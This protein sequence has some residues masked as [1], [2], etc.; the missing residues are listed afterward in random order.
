M[1][2]NIRRFS[3]NDIAKGVSITTA[4]NKFTTLEN[5]LANCRLLKI[6]PL[7]LIVL[8]CAV[9]T[10][11]S[12]SRTELFSGIDDYNPRELSVIFVDSLLFAASYF[13][14]I[15]KMAEIKKTDIF[16]ATVIIY[17]LSMVALPFLS[18]DIL[19]YVVGG[20]NIAEFHQNPY[21]VPIGFLPNPWS[22]EVAGNWWSAFPTPYGPFFL[23]VSSIAT[24]LSFGNI[25]VAIYSYKVI[26][27]AFY[28][29]TV[30]L[31]YKINKL[32]NKGNIPVYLLIL[33][34]AII[35]H[36]LIDTHNETIIA[37][38]LLASLY[39]LQAKKHGQGLL[40]FFLATLVKFTT[41]VVAPMFLNKKI[42]A[43]KLL[44]ISVGATILL[45]MILSSLLIT[46]R[47]SYSFLWGWCFSSCTPVIR[48]SIKTF[49]DH[50]DIARAILFLPFYG[51]VSYRFLIKEQNNLKYC[52]WVFLIF[53]FIFLRYLPPWYLII[54]IYIGLL[55]TGFK[56]KI[57][58][59]LL[60]IYSL[61]H[62]FGI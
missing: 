57:I 43:K 1:E 4:V 9:L 55:L 15:L 29:G 23:L 27:F 6:N 12:L 22:K 37:F 49:G 54:T 5:R 7:I 10:A 14:I 21:T 39:L 56:Y 40:I 20:R 36:L 61:I 53:Q 31:F 17:I 25:F 33:N 11:F 3:L 19:S 50:A 59:F 51:L 45:V 48:L 8:S 38:F 30:Y 62:I 42:L 13:L 44:T 26:N 60:T 2:S 52:F 46:N 34:P 58:M 35:V 24:L 32:I 28:L 41:L 18:V 47:D 16:I